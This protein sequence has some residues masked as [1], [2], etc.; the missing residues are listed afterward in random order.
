[1][2]AFYWFTRFNLRQFFRLFYR[3]KVYGVEAPVKGS[4]IIAPNH[5]SFFDP[6]IIAM[7][8]PEEVHFLAKAS[9]FDTFFMRWIIKNLNAHPIHEESAHNAQSFKIICKLL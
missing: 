3:C 9:L 2:K 5:T 6:P 8:W 7:A 4:A 1:M